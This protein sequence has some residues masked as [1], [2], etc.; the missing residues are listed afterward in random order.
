MIGNRKQKIAAFSHIP[1]DRQ[2][3]AILFARF[4]RYGQKKF[5][6]LNDEKAACYIH[7]MAT[8]CC[9]YVGPAEIFMVF[10]KP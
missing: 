8:S 1:A 7:L 9:V 10:G 4:Y 5:I 3:I 2:N 6:G